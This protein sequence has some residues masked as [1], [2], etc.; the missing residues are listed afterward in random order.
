MHTSEAEL[1][2][3]LMQGLGEDGP[4]DGSKDSII[5]GLINEL[6]PN[7]WHRFNLDA[8]MSARSLTATYFL[9]ERY[10]RIDEQVRRDLGA[11][12]FV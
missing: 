11:V 10:Y 8:G 9:K 12:S 6:D 5:L 1:I 7:F 4:G 2:V 3:R